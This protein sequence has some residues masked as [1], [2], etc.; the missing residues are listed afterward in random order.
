MTTMSVDMVSQLCATSCGQ[1][2][3][4]GKQCTQNAKVGPGNHLRVIDKKFQDAK[5]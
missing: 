1:N 5:I 4:F 2:F 3:R